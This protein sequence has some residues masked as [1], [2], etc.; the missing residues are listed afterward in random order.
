MDLV[1]FKFSCQRCGKCCKNLS[2]SVPLY[3][4]DVEQISFNLEL[5]I[6]GFLQQYCDV[7][8]Y[9][10]QK[11]DE[12]FLVPVLS[13][14]THKKI[15]PFFFNNLCTIHQFKPFL[16]KS[17]PFISLLFQNDN[18]FQFFKENCHGFGKGKFYTVKEISQKLMEEEN[19]EIEDFKTY[20][21]DCCQK[22]TQLFVKE[23]GNEKITYF[24]NSIPPI[25][26]WGKG[27]IKEKN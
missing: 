18:I 25:N 19:M 16:C 21:K 24:N 6:D 27:C 14:K 8:I 3:L 15:C 20:Q 17:A 22:L 10:Y 12:H 1:P 5:T 11:N 4:R 13:L 23:T 7:N 2:F 26:T 9:K